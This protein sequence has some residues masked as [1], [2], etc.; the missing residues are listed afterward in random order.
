M[1]LKQKLHD[2]V[3]LRDRSNSKNSKSPTF[4]QFKKYL[5]SQSPPWQTT[6]PQKYLFNEKIGF[7]KNDDID[8]TT[9]QLQVNLLPRSYNDVKN[10]LGV[11]FVTHAG[12]GKQI[13]QNEVVD[14]LNLFDPKY[15]GSHGMNRYTQPSFLMHQTLTKKSQPKQFQESFATPSLNN[16]SDY[17]YN[18]LQKSVVGQSTS[19]LNLMNKSP[20]MASTTFKQVFSS[21]A[22][23]ALQKSQEEYKKKLRQSIDL[24][25]QLDQ[26][27]RFDAQQRYE[28]SPQ[29]IKHHNPNGGVSGTG[30]FMD[31]KADERVVIR[32][33][34]SS[35]LEKQF[36]LRDKA[37]FKVPK[38]NPEYFKIEKTYAE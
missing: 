4:K 16:N 36:Q 2:A 30:Y 22:Q 33:K 8:N 10:N 32:D 26:T 27:R 15:S 28:T 18:T 6:D 35:K 25:K 23:L 13:F 20:S 9:L 31:L 37:G 12:S 14:P 11:P 3:P 29:W 19:N 5:S 34:D 24:N 17:S 1:E 21:T 38:K 7:L